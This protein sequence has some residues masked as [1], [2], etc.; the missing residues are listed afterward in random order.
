[1]PIV[2]G[3][4]QSSK[5]N[6]ES[7]HSLDVCLYGARTTAHKGTSIFYLSSWRNGNWC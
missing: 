6:S 2:E 5:L 4:A 3:T 1:V 7:K